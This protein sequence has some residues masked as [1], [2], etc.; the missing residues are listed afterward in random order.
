LA[1]EFSVDHMT[2]TEQEAFFDLL[3]E[4]FDGPS[5]AVEKFFAARKKSGGGAGRD[6]QGRLVRALPGGGSEAIG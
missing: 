3:G 5:P 1:G 2:E 6:E 4:H